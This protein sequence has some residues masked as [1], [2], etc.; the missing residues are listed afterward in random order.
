MHAE[1]WQRCEK[2]LTDCLVTLSSLVALVNKIKD[3][4]NPKGKG[5]RWRAK[6]V[7]DMSIHGDDLVAFREKIQKSNIALQT[8]LH[9]I[10]L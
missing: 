2:A 5:L 6:V 9:T 4:T 1:L 7:V 10:T 8:M 3:T